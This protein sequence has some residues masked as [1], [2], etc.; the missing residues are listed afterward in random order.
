L[1]I[2]E[3]QT[4][5]TNNPTE[6]DYVVNLRYTITSTYSTSQPSGISD[7]MTVTFH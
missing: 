7:T 4:Y 1:D 2:A 5:F 3:V 6:A